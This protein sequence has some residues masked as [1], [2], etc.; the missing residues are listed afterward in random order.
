M[1]LFFLYINKLSNIKLYTYKSKINKITYIAYTR[2]DITLLQSFLMNSLYV[3][4]I[5]ELHATSACSFIV[6]FNGSCIIHSSVYSMMT[7]ILTEKMLDV[8]ITNWDSR[9]HSLLCL[10][11][12]MQR[13][14][15][16]PWFNVLRYIYYKYTFKKKPYN[17]EFFIYTRYSFVKMYTLATKL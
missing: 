9:H 2:T 12:D 5:C 4:Y 8:H 16:W 14:V 17:I 13:H 3:Y 15:G 6:L 7:L 11:R 10:Y 1:Y